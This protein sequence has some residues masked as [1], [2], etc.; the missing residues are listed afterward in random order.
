M[1]WSIVHGGPV[2]HSVA[3]DVFYL[4]FDLHDQVVPSRGATVICEERIFNLIT[5]LLE[6]NCDEDLKVL[7]NGN[8]DW[9]FDQ[10]ISSHGIGRSACFTDANIVKNP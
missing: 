7:R 4:M 8:S 9:L 3:D 1:A 10:G 5:C 6:V 2:P